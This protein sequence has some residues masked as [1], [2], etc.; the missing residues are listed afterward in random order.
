MRYALDASAAVTSF[1]LHRSLEMKRAQV[2][3]SQIRLAPFDQVRLASDH[4]FIDQ[5]FLSYQAVITDD[6]FEKDTASFGI[7]HSAPKV[8]VARPDRGVVHKIVVRV[9]F[10]LAD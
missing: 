5:S 10:L 9:D 2:Q 1:R 7:V 6:G 8:S 4:D 3:G